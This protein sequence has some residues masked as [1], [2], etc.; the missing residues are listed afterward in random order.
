MASP[1]SLAIGIAEERAW[2]QRRRR[3]L[4]VRPQQAR[5]GPALGRSHLAKAS[6]G[7]ATPVSLAG[8]RGCR[9]D[10]LP[11]PGDERV[12]QLS[13]GETCLAVVAVLNEDSGDA[14]GGFPNRTV[15]GCS[16]VV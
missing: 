1:I 15:L 8:S 10:Q 4:D 5:D 3:T 13:G 9:P 11:A 14:P 12:F 6:A 2:L 7:S 16:R